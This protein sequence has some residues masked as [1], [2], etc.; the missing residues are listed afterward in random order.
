MPRSLENARFAEERPLVRWAAALAVAL[1]AFAL[2]HATLLPG[3]DFGDSA[4]IQTTVGSPLLTPRDGYPLYFAIG[5]VLW[6]MTG[7]AP[8]Y[9]MNLTSALEA[10][11]ACGLFVLVAVDVTGSILSAIAGAL[12][13]AASYTFWSQAVTAEVYALHISFVLASM[14]MLLRWER[15]PSTGRLAAFFCCYALGFGNHLSMILLFPAFAAFILAAEPRGWRSLVSAP[16]L[17]LAVAIAAAGAAQY[18]WNLRTL[19]FQPDPPASL[20]AAIRAF[21]FDVTKS[22]WRDTM[23][24]NVPHTMI[25]D[26]AAMYW[27]DLRQQFGAAALVVAAFGGLRLVRDAPGRAILLW[28]IFAVNLAFAFGYNVG[29][30][31]VFYLPAHLVVALFAAYGVAAIARPDFPR[32]STLAAAALLLYAG[33]RA[34]RDFPALDRHADTRSAGVLAR[35]THGLDDRHNVVLVDLNWQIANGLSYFT[36]VVT[37]QLAAARMRDVLL[38]APALVRDNLANGRDIVLTAQASHILTGSYG[39][40]FSPAQDGERSSLRDVVATLPRG[41]RYVLCVLKPTRDFELDRTDLMA[42]LQR[43]GARSEGLPTADYYALAGTVGDGPAFIQQ[44]N[45]PFARSATVAGVSTDIRMESWLSADTIR[46]M[47]FGH[48]IASR[49]HTLIVERGVSF[50]AFDD[51]GTPITT[52]Y[53]SNIFA[54]LPRFV[55]T[56]K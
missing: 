26:H 17:G 39:P 9:A 14:L 41:T 33:A 15:R 21:W 24:L 16:V 50:V 25:R 54:E 22:D 30:T 4:S 12:L 6:K 56:R 46:R 29:D 27:F 7:A 5:A 8:A 3:V 47:G 49:H 40:L 18:G 55:I 13:F 38:Y 11:T 32:G 1:A 28:M 52:A 19:W 53:Y 2:Y 48:V 37:P 42:A 51:R 35:F 20:S 31:H 23:V 10:A 45:R 36:K 34:Y 43:L 44:S